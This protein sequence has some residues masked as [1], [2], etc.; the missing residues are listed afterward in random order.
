[1]IPMR[2]ILALMRLADMAD[3]K[4]LQQCLGDKCSP[5]I[6]YVSDMA[7]VA[8]QLI[9]VRLNSPARL[10]MTQPSSHPFQVAA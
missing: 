10:A 4:I 7:S 2:K 8:I 1:M 9:V 3:T 6:G 5:E